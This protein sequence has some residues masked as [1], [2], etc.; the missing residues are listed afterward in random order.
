MLARQKQWLAVEG[1]HC[2]AD[3]R[4]KC[5]PTRL[6]Q[7]GILESSNS[8][9]MSNLLSR[10][11]ERPVSS[12]AAAVARCCGLT[13]G[14]MVPKTDVRVLSVVT[15]GKRTWP[16]GQHRRASFTRE[17]LQVACFP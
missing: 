4:H 15:W 3:S 6:S 7:A 11:P 1:P 10:G 5:W 12:V 17:G 16:L 8:M 14:F 9:R 13:C 2:I